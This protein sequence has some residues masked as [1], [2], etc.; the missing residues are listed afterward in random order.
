MRSHINMILVILCC[1]PLL[2]NAANIRFCFNNKNYRW[3]QFTLDSKLYYN[4]RTNS[5]NCADH[6]SLGSTYVVL[7]TNGFNLNYKG[8]L[9]GNTNPCLIAINQPSGKLSYIHASVAE[10]NN[11]VSG[12]LFAQ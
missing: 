7:F 5:E 10:E 1:F 2:S 6:T 4:N 8:I 3:P 11:I 9:C 12:E